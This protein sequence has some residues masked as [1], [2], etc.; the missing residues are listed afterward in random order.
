MIV[1]PAGIEKGRRHPATADHWPVANDEEAAALPA[2]DDE[3]ADIVRSRHA[4]TVG[5][6]PLVASHE[7][8]EASWD[9]ILDTNLKGVF[10]C[11]AAAVPHMIE[12]GSGEAYSCPGWM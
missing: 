2:G 9:A 6:P 1:P 7:L 3:G 12:Q 10:F 11:A 4:A 8:P 5:D